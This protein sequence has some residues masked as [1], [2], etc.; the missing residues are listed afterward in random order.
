MQEMQECRGAWEKNSRKGAGYRRG[1]EK[2]SS[3]RTAQEK[4]IVEKQENWRL[5]Y[6]TCNYSVK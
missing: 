2:H 4:A 5:G 3:R 1:T 6:N